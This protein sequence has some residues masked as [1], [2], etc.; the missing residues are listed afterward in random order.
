MEPIDWL[1]QHVTGFQDLPGEDRHAILCFAL[2]WSLFEA[3]ALNARAS[4]HALL[5][6]VHENEAGKGD[7]KHKGDEEIPY[8][9]TTP[10]AL[11]D[12][13]W[14]EVDNWRP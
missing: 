13:F 5:A 14:Q 10:Q 7:H 6:L 1:E 9:F 4:A 2:L 12:D 3:K 8:F 11:L